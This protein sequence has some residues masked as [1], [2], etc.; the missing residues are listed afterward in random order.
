MKIPFG[1][2]QTAYRR[3]LASMRQQTASWA[4][5]IGGMLAGAFAVRGAIMKFREAISFGSQM[6]DLATRTS[7]TVREF[8]VWRDVARDAGVE[9]SVLE[10][11]LRN[12]TIRFQ[13]AKDGTKSYADAFKRLGIDMDAFNNL[14]TSDRL[15]EVARAFHLASDK[16]AAFADV[17][18]ILGVRAGPQLIEVLNK[19][20]RDGFESVA[21]S[22]VTMSDTTARELDRAEDRIQRFKDRVLIAFGKIASGWGEAMES[23]REN[24]KLV[25]KMMPARIAAMEEMEAEVKARGGK[26]FTKWEKKVLIDPREGTTRDRLDIEERH[27]FKRNEFLRRV[28]KHDKERSDAE[29]KQFQEQRAREQAEKQAA[30]DRRAQAEKEIAMEELKEDIAKQQAKLKDQLTT[31]E[32]KLRDL[33]EER[34]TLEAQ[35]N[36]ETVKGLEAKKKAAELD[37]E[38]AKIQPKVDAERQKARE[39]LAN[40][41]KDLAELQEQN[42]FELLSDEEQLGEL[43]Q[44]QAKE[45]E[46]ADFLAEVGN[47]KGEVEARIKAQ[48][49][50]QEIRAKGEEI[51]A[52]ADAANQNKLDVPTITTSGLQAIAGGGTAATVTIDPAL[53]IGKQ[54]VE[55]LQQIAGNTSV[56]ANAPANENQPVM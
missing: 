40:K 5:G 51:Q 49:L 54:Q 18:D 38:I 26:G 25:G 23:F 17:A 48:E 16:T 15:A 12:V 2:D 50:E 19:V 32:E 30:A 46:K 36:D 45:Q 9:V 22:A 43:K 21:E 1:V 39:D 27:G 56:T 55:L 42:R 35:I 44:K 31:D 28:I 11:A 13:E 47:R 37:T 34:A 10:R 8:M 20:G 53:I 14:G 6:S 7:T 33:A 24:A 29:R 52:K 4:K 3:G 41:E